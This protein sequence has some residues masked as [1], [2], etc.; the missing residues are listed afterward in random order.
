MHQL[1]G[2]R[3]VQR[4][5]SCKKAYSELVEFCVKCHLKIYK[6]FLT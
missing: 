1:N 5:I 6:N 4:K 3:P 2:L